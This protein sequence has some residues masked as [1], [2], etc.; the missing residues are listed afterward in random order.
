MK[1]ALVGLPPKTTRPQLILQ[2]Y[3]NLRGT[4]LNEHDIKM[5]KS[6]HTKIIKFKKLNKVDNYQK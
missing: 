1:V 6:K 3:P 5:K 4:K 2:Q